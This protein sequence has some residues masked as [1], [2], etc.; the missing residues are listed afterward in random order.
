MI[1]VSSVSA[2]SL[3]PRRCVFIFVSFD[4][5]KFGEN[6]DLGGKGECAIGF[7]YLKND[8]KL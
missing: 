8:M 3:T 4:T 1:A 7:H 5:R 6:D 2:R